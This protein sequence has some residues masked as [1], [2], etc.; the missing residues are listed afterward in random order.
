[1]DPDVNRR[2][3]QKRLKACGNALPTDHQAAIL[4]LEPGKGALRLKA[5]DCLFDRSPPGLFRLPDALR[6]LR[7]DTP[8]PELLPQRLRILPFICRNP[9]ETFAGATAFARAH[10]DR[11]EQR[12]SLRPLIPIGR[13]DA[14]RQ[15]HAAPLGEAVDEDPLAFPPVRDA[16]AATLPRGKKRHR[17]RHTPNESCHVLRQFPESGLASRPMCHWPASAAA[18]DA[19][20][21]LIP[22]AAHEGCHTSDNR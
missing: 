14:I 10:L 19:W 18:T 3:S 17:R 11:I 21:S 16:L 2:Q 9:F 4:L 6:D 12:H 1:M 22:I 8:L 5:W 7:P 15:G 13:R 20:R